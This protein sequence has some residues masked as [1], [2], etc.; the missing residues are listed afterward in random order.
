MQLSAE[1]VAIYLRNGGR[2]PEGALAAR[3]SELLAEA[4]LAPRTLGCR[5]GERVYL[6]GT[7]GAAF[8]AWQ[9]RLSV[10]SAADALVAQ[11][12]GAAAIERTMDELERETAAAVLAPGETLSPRRSPG[13]GDLPLTLS[14]EILEH[15]DAPRRIGVTLTESLLLVPSKSVTAV[16]TVVREG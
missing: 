10:T 12:I 8:D 14:R 5:D 4:P 11:A 7:V 16:C 13:Y 3:V 6:C 15:L 1:E 2:L 9:R